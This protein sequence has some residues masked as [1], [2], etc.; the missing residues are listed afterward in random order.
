MV[1][2]EGFVYEQKPLSVTRNVVVWEGPMVVGEG[3]RSSGVLLY[4]TN[5]MKVGHA[6]ILSKWLVQVYE[7][8]AM[9]HG[10]DYAATM[11]KGFQRLS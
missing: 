9:N 11:K 8:C 2:R 10:S 6:G 1:A 3:G 7:L 4:L 5:I